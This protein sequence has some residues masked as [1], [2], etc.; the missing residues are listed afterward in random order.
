MPPTVALSLR[1][2][3]D[4]PHPAL[5]ADA[6]LLL[7][8][9]ELPEDVELSIVLCDD[10]FITEL[11][12]AWRDRDRPTDV[13]SFAQRE[14]DGG[15]EDDPILGDVVIS[16]QTAARQ[17]AA[18]QLTLSQEIRILLVHGLLHLLGYDHRDDEERAEMEAEERAL[19]AHLGED[20]DRVR[21]LTDPRRHE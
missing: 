21:P 10:G 9:Y 8:A 12:A 4:N 17:A 13:L 6:R 15:R 1:N 19:L 2:L 20:V 3:V 14:G 16:V 5:E 7:G 11:N 18:R